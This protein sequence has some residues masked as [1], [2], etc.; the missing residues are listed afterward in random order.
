[1]T[2]IERLS[3]VRTDPFTFTQGLLREMQDFVHARQ[4]GGTRPAGS[5]R[6]QRD[7]DG[8]TWL[9]AVFQT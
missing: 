9:K 2:A 6:E 4:G 5:Q 8:Q 7:H 3:I 1:M